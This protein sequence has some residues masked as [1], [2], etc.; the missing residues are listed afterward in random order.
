MCAIP[1]FTNFT[2]ILYTN[3]NQTQVLKIKKKLKKYR[4]IMRS[5]KV[6]NIGEKH[7]TLCAQISCQV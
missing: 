4:T 1:T 6:R 2:I 5:G 7:V 3:K